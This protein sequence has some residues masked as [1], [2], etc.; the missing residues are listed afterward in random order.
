MAISERTFEKQINNNTN[1]Q[2]LIVNPNALEGGFQLVIAIGLSE[3]STLG[4]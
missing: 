1:L 3:N 4:N 2:H